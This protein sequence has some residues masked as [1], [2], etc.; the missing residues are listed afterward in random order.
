MALTTIKTTIKISKNKA[1]SAKAFS[2]SVLGWFDEHGRKHLPWQQEKSA[3]RVWVSEIM[4][5]QT[6]VTTVIPYFEA[7]MARFPTVATLADA[8]LDAVL[9]LWAG[10]GYYARARNL[11]KA[12]QVVRDEHGGEFPVRF[13]EVLALP[14]IGRSTA[15]AILSL[16]LN[17]HHAILDGNVKRVLARVFTEPGWPGKT[18]VAEKLWRHSEYLTPAKRV[19]DFNQAMM[20]LGASICSRSRPRCEACPLKESCRA[21]AEGQQ[22]DYPGKKPKKAIPVRETQMLIL[23][24]DDS[25]VLLQRRP[26]TGIWGGLLSLP[27][28]PVGDDVSQWCEK[29]LGFAVAEQQRWPMV[30][31]TFSHFHLDITPVVIEALAVGQAVN[32]NSPT[33]SVMEG[34]DWVWYKGS[35]ELG[36]LPAPVSRLLEKVKVKQPT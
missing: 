33:M 2:Q 20:D 15:G 19:A 29:N 11:H 16:A 13:D 6:Q 24:N 28:V 22:S 7:F 30:R 23:A 31:H 5:Q 10:L 26:P 36:G 21:Y 14:G 35:A 34:P 32:N 4:L 25:E 18:A 1:V 9:G 8:P 27:E 3:Y 12:A 17:Q